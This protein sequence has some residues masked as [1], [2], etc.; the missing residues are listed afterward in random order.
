MHIISSIMIAMGT[1]FMPGLRLRLL[2]RVLR[3]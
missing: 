3:L 1:T 2:A